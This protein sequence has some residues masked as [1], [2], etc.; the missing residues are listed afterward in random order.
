MTGLDKITGQIL[1]DAREKA[2]GILEEADLDCRRMAEEYATRAAEIRETLTAEGQREGEDLVAR[3]RAASQMAERSILLA[4]RQEMVDEAF[5]RAKAQLSSTDYGKYK[6]L[7]VALLASALLT[8]HRTEER[9]LLL[10]DE[11][12]E[13]DSFEVL[14]CARDKERFGTAVV[15]SA[16]K[17]T[18]R[19]IGAENAAKLRLSAECADIEGGL[20]LRFGNV[21]LNCSL[22]IIMAEI[23]RDLEAKVSAILFEDEGKGK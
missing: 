3:A 19:H 5:E 2:R 1:A 4:A 11:V 17:I 16:R 14:L 22:P 21:E 20:V 8:Q 7:L 23:R 12:A 10:G 15:E 6:E 18:E 13:F 9:S